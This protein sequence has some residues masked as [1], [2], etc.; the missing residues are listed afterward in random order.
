MASASVTLRE[1]KS[2]TYTDGSNQL[3]FT[4]DAATPVQGEELITKLETISCL[5][6]ARNVDKPVTP[7]AT[8]KGPAGKTQPLR[9]F[10]KVPPAPP[11]PPEPEAT[12][13]EPVEDEPGEGDD[14]G[15]VADGEEPAAEE[16]VEDEPAVDPEPVK[17]AQ[18]GG[19]GNKP[20]Q[21]GG[22]G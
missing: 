3:K 2:Y 16:V 6:V 5:H 10:G 9:P 14:A 8:S 11:P 20:G 17:P 19:K 12:D 21:K 18:K 7:L 1:G 13:D 4:C 22:K 15:E